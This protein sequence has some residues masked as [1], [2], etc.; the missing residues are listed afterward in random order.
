MMMVTILVIV[1]HGKNRNGSFD[2]GATGLIAKGEN[3]YYREDFFPAVRKYLPVGHNVVLFEDYNVYDRQNL[4]TLAKSYGNDTVVI[5]MHYDALGH[6][7]NASG[8]H[9][10]VHQDYAPDKLDIQLRDW[11]K[12]HIGVRYQHQGHD[13]ISGRNDLQNC[14]IARNNNINYRLIELGFGTNKQ[15]ADT[16]VNNVDAI[17]KDFV[18]VLC[19]KVK[20]NPKTNKPVASVQ[21]KQEGVIQMQGTFTANDTIIVRDQPTTKG[22]RIATYKKGESL[23]YEAVHFKNGYVW[24]QYIRAVGGYGYIP[25]APLNELWGTLK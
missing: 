11:I 7:P 9:V 24:L 23:V 12:K 3:R 20:E 16:M 14:N 25:I 5:E 6:A 19:G 2:P 8:G 15:D 13:G 18:Q 17:A 4:A 1:G 22:N 21:T 10:I